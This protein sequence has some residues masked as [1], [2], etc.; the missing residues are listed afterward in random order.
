MFGPRTAL[1]WL[2]CS[3]F[4]GFLV[5][6]CGRL[7]YEEAPSGDTNAGG[8][9]TIGSRDA[10]S[11]AGGG[12]AGASAV[13]SGGRG[14]TGSDLDA[15]VGG[16]GGRDADGAP[17]D[18]SDAAQDGARDAG[19]VYPSCTVARR[20]ALDFDQ[21]PTLYDGDGDGVLDWVIRDGSTFPTG[22][23]LGGIWRSPGTKVLDS[24]PLYDFASRTLVDVRLRSLTVPVSH[25]GAVFWINVNEGAPAF[26]A[27]F[28]S[29]VLQPGG[30]QELTLF[31]KP[32]GATE[33]PLATFPDLPEGFVAVHLDIEPSTPSVAVWTDGVLRGTYSV[34]LTGVPNGDRFATILSWEG[35]SEFDSVQVRSCAP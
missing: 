30:G 21:D 35:V 1:S 9:T 31:G 28:V 10:M 2:G 11:E 15:T 16:E 20:W 26:S 27:L 23:L 34:P 7:G 24:R 32:D 25:R 6:S 14:G 8:G 13:G 29:V 33:V 17:R 22:E 12:G 18:A 3:F 19:D 5:L 4:G